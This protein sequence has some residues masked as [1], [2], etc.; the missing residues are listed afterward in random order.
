MSRIV[1]VALL[2]FFLLPAVVS[3]ETPKPEFFDRAVSSPEV[4]Q[5]LTPEQKAEMQA[6]LTS[7]PFESE[8]GRMSVDSVFANIDQESYAVGDEA[9]VVLSLASAAMTSYAEHH[10]DP[11]GAPRLSA[12]LSL[13]GADGSP[14]AGPLPESFPISDTAPIFT[15]PV[16]VSC[17]R[18]A[19]SVALSDTFGRNLGEWMIST[20]GILPESF[21]PKEEPVPTAPVSD[22]E[23][24][25]FPIRTVAIAIVAVLFLVAAGVIVAKRRGVF[26]LLGLFSSALLMGP[27]DVFAY[28]VSL[29]SWTSADHDNY[30]SLHETVSAPVGQWTDYVGDDGN[31]AVGSGASD[32]QGFKIRA[33]VD[34]EPGDSFLGS[35]DIRRS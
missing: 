3:A 34:G 10:P 16:S 29:E 1:S 7:L 17:D 25:S 5:S 35:L 15:L 2:A 11:A 8:E 22:T 14:C 18:P 31:G 13:L 12:T 4:R 28:G 24:P 32:D 30:W 27:N 21:L 9:Y 33:K 26:L 6:Y 23:S 20:P 19:V